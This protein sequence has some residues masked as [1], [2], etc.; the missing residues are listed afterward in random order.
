MA[1]CINLHWKGGGGGK[2]KKKRKKNLYLDQKKIFFYFIPN[3]I[4][5]NYVK[6][7]VQQELG[8]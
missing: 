4:P 7:F 1:R 6:N 5:L 3:T 2:K 8:Q